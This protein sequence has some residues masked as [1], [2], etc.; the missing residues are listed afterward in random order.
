MRAPPIPAR[1]LSEAFE[2]A[3]DEAIATPDASELI[4]VDLGFDRKLTLRMSAKEGLLLPD[5][6]PQNIH[7][8]VNLCNTTGSDPYYKTDKE[9][10]IA[11]LDNAH[12]PIHIHSAK[13][14]YDLKSDQPLRKTVQEFVEEKVRAALQPK[15]S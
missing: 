1:Q 15:K 9:G 12:G 11:R 14:M 4:T 6:P 8:S 3:L 5:T 10:T 7:I 2:K 13:R